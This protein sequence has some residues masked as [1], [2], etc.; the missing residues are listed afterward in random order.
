MTN[1]GFITDKKFI[2]F[3]L[4]FAGCF[5]LFYWGTKAVIAFASPGGYYNS[6][7]AGYLDYVSGLKILI[8]KSVQLLLS[9]FGIETQMGAAFR[10]GIVGGKAV[11]VAMSCVGYGVYS[12]WLAYIIAS[13]GSFKSRTLW[14]VVGLFLLFFINIVRIAA[15]LYAHNKGTKMP[16]GLDH[17]TW[18]NLMAYTLIFGMIYFHESQQTKYA[19]LEP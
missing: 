16:L 15:F 2:R 13:D 6:F 18:F 17:H 8:I 4:T 10:V 3:L 12:F 14:A 5:L 7:V 1:L 19:K 9:V 11:V